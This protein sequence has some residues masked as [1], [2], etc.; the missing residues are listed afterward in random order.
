MNFLFFNALFLYGCELI[1]RVAHIVFART[2]RS[3][4]ANIAALRRQARSL[5]RFGLLCKVNKKRQ[6]KP[7]H[8]KINFIIGRIALSRIF[9]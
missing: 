9:S 8:Y 3:P 6:A 1:S 4:M 5:V 2:F 7:C